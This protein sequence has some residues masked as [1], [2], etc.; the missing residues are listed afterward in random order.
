[1]SRALR[2]QP[3][4]QKP[5]AK[6]PSFRAAGARPARKQAAAAAET[7][8]KRSLGD[9]LL[10]Q[11]AR[12]IIT[13][14]RKVSWPPREETTRLTG[15]VIAVAVTIGLLLGGVDLGFNWLVEHTLLR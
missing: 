11:F 1:M 14:L 5:P 8:R 3:L 9:R 10:P 4:V 2:R 6:G 7:A 12:D 13:E 15:V